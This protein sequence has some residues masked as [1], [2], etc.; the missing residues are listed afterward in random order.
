VEF[1]RSITLLIRIVGIVGNAMNARRAIMSRVLRFDSDG[2]PFLGDPPSNIYTIHPP[3]SDLILLYEVV[4]K[5]GRGLW[6]GED[7]LEAI[8]WLRLNLRDECR[9]LVSA[10]DSD[11]ED[12]HLVGQSIDITDIILEAFKEGL[13]V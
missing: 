9:L 4:D 7:S 1:V 2:K 3:K 11:E 8:K 10:W 13:R 5:Q 6:G 12:A